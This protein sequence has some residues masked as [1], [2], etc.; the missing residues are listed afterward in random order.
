[1]NYG[2]AHRRQSL[3]IAKCDQALLENYINTKGLV[4]EDVEDAFRLLSKDGK[5]ITKSDIKDFADKY[6][7]GRLKM[8]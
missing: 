4:Q 7:K 2:K 3:R 1:M 6:F 5:K 8:V